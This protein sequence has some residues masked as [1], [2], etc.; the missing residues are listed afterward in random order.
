MVKLS[1]NKNKRPI[2]EKIIENL[3][4]EVKDFPK[5]ILKRYA[6]EAF[7]STAGWLHNTG[8]LICKVNL[9]LA[10]DRKY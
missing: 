4:N 10:G 8:G 2:K 7:K 1:L 6:V 5:T 9:Y 3:K